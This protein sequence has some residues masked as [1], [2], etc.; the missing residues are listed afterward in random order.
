MK[1]CRTYEEKWPAYLEGLVSAAEKEKLE[2]HLASC[3]EC[4]RTVAELK[5][6]GLLLAGLRPYVLE[7][8]VEVLIRAAGRR[9]R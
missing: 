3:E 6:T 2:E 5:K 1:P 4:R 8:P 7:T 9:P